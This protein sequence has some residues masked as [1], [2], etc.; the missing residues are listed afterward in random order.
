MFSRPRI[1]LFFVAICLSA[2]AP[3]RA[4]DL[5]VYTE[6]FPP[7]NYPAPDGSVAG[8]STDVVRQVLDRAGMPYE[9]KLVPWS[10]AVQLSLAD[11]NALIYTLART[12]KRDRDYDWLVPLVRSEYHLFARSEDSREVTLEALRSGTFRTA[13]VTANIS[14]EILA[15]MGVPSDKLTR[16]PNQGT[17]DM[18]M[19]LAGRADVYFND[20]DGHRAQMKQAG[21]SPFLFRDAMQVPYEG[22]FYLAAGRQVPDEVRAK[23]HRAYEVLLGE[24][25]VTAPGTSQ[26]RPSV[27]G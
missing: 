2:G 5:V 18:Q 10:R 21:L 14:C 20:L 17:L 7:Y 16:L 9:I 6:D 15:W 12:P 24:G 25:A 8:T 4:A 1:F 27:G 13:C 26:S 3:L 23:I 11:P 19:V 22:G